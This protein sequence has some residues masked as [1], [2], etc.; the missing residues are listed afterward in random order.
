MLSE[1]FVLQFP[2]V[3]FEF[4]D[5]VFHI[6]DHFLEQLTLN[7]K[8]IDLDPIVFVVLNDALFV[9]GFHLKLFLIPFLKVVLPFLIDLQLFC[10]FCYFVSIFLHRPLSQLQL[11][12][13]L[14]KLLLQGGVHFVEILSLLLQSLVRK[15]CL[16]V[17]I[18]HCT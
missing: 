5:N 7:C 3:L 11:V 18:C 2:F 4:V 8:S 12:F 6:V 14:L 13:H 9:V 10:V 15:I 16:F 17:L 1:E